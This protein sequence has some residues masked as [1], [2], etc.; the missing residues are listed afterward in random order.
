MEKQVSDRKLAAQRLNATRSTG[1][2][3]QAGKLIS[4]LNAMTH[5]L[6][7]RHKVL[8]APPF[9]ESLADYI[10]LR[11]D[12]RAEFNPIGILEEIA[13][14]GITDGIWGTRRVARHDAAS[15]MATARR[16][17][18]RH[19]ELISEEEVPMSL[20][21]KVVPELFRELINL[22]DHFKPGS[23]GKDDEKEF[24]AF[25]WTTKNPSAG[26]NQEG[27]KRDWITTAREYITNLS[28]REVQDLKAAF[29]REIKRAVTAMFD[30]RAQEVVLESA[31]VRSLIPDEVE[32]E[33]VIRAESRYSRQI[34][35]N[36]DTLL[37][38]QARRE[39]I[40][41]VRP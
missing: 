19:M 32:L 23:G 39:R 2:R 24:L 29:R 4:S 16:A 8:V 5:G 30:K 6:Y 36:L 15:A 35:R 18:E 33:R 40:G 11:E 28:E 10:S 3:T 12:L 31:V 7:S 26:A 13:I 37:K 1:P 14:E 27:T 25:V 9:S 22:A 21:E 41:G 38:L 17:A 20:T 34:T